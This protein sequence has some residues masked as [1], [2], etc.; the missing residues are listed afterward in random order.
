MIE[1]IIMAGIIAIIVGTSLCLNHYIKYGVVAHPYEYYGLKDHG[2]IGLLII[3]G[4]TIMLLAA[5]IA[6]ALA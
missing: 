1:T 2:L 6:L 4:G 5:M 3:L